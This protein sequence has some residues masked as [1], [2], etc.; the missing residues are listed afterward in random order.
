M[1]RKIV[2][3]QDIF[4]EYTQR[5]PERFK[6]IPE[7][8]F[9]AF[10]LRPMHKLKDEVQWQNCS[11]VHYAG[12]LKPWQVWLPDNKTSLEGGADEF[13][14][15]PTDDL[16]KDYGSNAEAIAEPAFERMGHAC[17]AGSLESCGGSI[18]Y[19]EYNNKKGL[20]RSK[21]PVQVRRHQ[22]RYRR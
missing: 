22:Y 20:K 8:S 3:D 12:G 15:I 4:I 2:T 17:M 11:V 21:R 7:A 6:V 10:N 5:F 1:W 18:S 14:L 9:P 19:R 13:P 16:P